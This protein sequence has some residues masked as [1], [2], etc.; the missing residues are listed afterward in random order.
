MSYLL[1][2]CVI[3]ELRKPVSTKIREW[4]ESKDELSFYISVV[5]I[6]EL[7]DGVERHSLQRRP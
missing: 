6:V 3:S 1:D 5:T 4:L 2:T 7:L